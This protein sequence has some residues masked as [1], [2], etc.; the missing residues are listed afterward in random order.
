MINSRK[1]SVKAIITFVLCVEEMVDEETTVDIAGE[2]DVQYLKKGLDVVELAV[3]KKDIFRIKDEIAINQNKP[4]ISEVVWTSVQIRNIDTK[5]GDGNITI[6]GELD[7]FILY[8]G[9]D[10]EGSLQW[11]ETTLPF[12]GTID[13]SGCHDEMIGD[14][15]ITIEHSDLEAKPDYDGEQRLINLD[16]ALNLDI[17]L[18]EE[19]HAEIVSDVY[20]PHKELSP[21]TQIANFESLVVKNFAKHRVTERIK[22]PGNQSRILQICHS[23]G[24]IKLDEIIPLEDA[25]SVEGVIEVSILYITADDN[26][27]FNVVKGVIPFNHI[28]EAKGM[29]EDAIV[30][31]KASLDQLSSMMID[32]EE[33]EVKAVI[34]LNAIVLNKVVEG[35]I[36]EVRESALDYAKLEVLP[37]IVGYVVKN[38]DTLWKLAKKYYTTVD[39]I[40]AN[41]DMTNDLIKAGDTLLIVKD[42]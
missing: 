18:Y 14:I 31:I 24:E 11:M 26:V 32:S 10:E 39:K 25:V 9:E 28:I 30:N 4:N 41:N 29:D 38:D 19:D 5:L 34:N 13:C 8:K 36:T 2:P 22:I 6:K 16:G 35:I 37:G 17:K 7:I 42:I 40:K 1:I 27:P 20:S 21:V 23:A 33:I 15:D 3:N 12:G